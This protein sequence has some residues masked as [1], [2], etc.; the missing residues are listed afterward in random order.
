MTSPGQRGRASSL[1]SSLPRSR[2][3][4]W[5]V[6]S[7]PTS[8]GQPPIR[9]RVS[10]RMS[11]TRSS[12]AN[13]EQHSQKR[14]SSLTGFFNR[15][16]PSSRPEQGGTRRTSNGTGDDDADLAM[17]PNEL[18]GWNLAQEKNPAYLTPMPPEEFNH[19]RVWSWS[20]QKGDS[21]F[22]ENLPRDRSRGREQR[23]DTADREPLPPRKSEALTR[24]E[25][26]ELLKS[27]EETRRSRRSLKESGDWLGVQGADPYSGKFAVLTPTDTPSSETTNTSTRSRLA[28]LARKK[29]T[30]KLEY[31]QI[32]VLEEQEKDK[33]KLDKEQAKLN[34]IERVKEDLRR[35]NQFAKWRQHKRQWSSAA[36]PNLS[37]IAQ[38]VDSVAL[39]SSENSS[40]LSSGMPTDSLSSDVED[41]A[42]VV[43]NFS[44]P[45]RPP[46]S[47]KAALQAHAGRLSSDSTGH[48]GHTR[49]NLSSD[50]VI[51]NSSGAN[52]EHV[53]LTRPATQ[54]SG[55]HHSV[56]Q[57]DVERVKSE[58]HF[59]WRRRRVTDPGKSAISRA[60]S[61]LMSRTAQNL[62]FNTTEHVQKDH[63]ADLAIPDYHLHLL[64]PEGADTADS[65]STLS[66]G[67]PS[68]TPNQTSLG[69]SGNRTALSSSTN[70][71]NLQE[72]GRTSQ[73]RSRLTA[74]SSQSKLKGIMRR[75]SIYRRL[76]QNRL[77]S[78]QAK[79]TETHQT[80]PPTFS[81]VQDHA[82]EN[83]P[84]PTQ[85]FQSQHLPSDQI[86]RISI[87]R[88]GNKLPH[89][90]NHIKPTRRESVSTPITTITGCVPDQQNQPEPRQ[91]KWNVELNQM[92]GAATLTFPD[93]DIHYVEPVQMP[94]KCMTP[95][96]P[97]TPRSGSS[98]RGL[99]QATPVIGTISV[100]HVTLEK[101]PP[102]RISTPTTP[103]LCRII[104]HNAEMKEIE[105]QNDTNGMEKTETIRTETSRRTESKGTNTQNAPVQ[106]SDQGRHGASPARN[107]VTAVQEAR[108]R[109]SSEEQRESMVEEAAR[110]AV[111]RS[112]AKE[113][114]RSKSADR[115]KSRTPSPTRRRA[116]SNH[117]SSSYNKTAELKHLPQ[118]QQQK[119]PRKKRPSEDAEGT[120]LP[121]RPERVSRQH[122]SSSSRCATADSVERPDAVVVAAAA[123][124]CKT[125]YIV[126]LG[127]ACTWWIMVQ[128]AFDQQSELWRRKHKKE[129]TWKDVGVFTSAGMFCLA[130]ALGGWYSLKALWWAVEQ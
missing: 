130:G 82:T 111:L 25:V 41:N 81:E 57:G 3:S 16:L 51:H 55:K 128:P 100:H 21:R 17:N 12:A 1:F 79:N 54:P 39:G 71:V 64:S 6:S 14:T 123:R 20:P 50:T 19:R 60:R 90:G 8:Q 127:L 37:P 95:S 67:S 52:L 126:F 125:I 11:P 34:K 112:R 88:A 96:P 89:I 4:D 77:A 46:V 28:S 92:D 87:E 85:E 61:R 120:G 101:K 47:S 58:R 122:S 42:S 69:I 26:H 48:Q 124:F 30:A 68:M 93:R 103:R 106:K 114:V 45:T 53:P 86:G 99:A 43:P 33:A 78:T 35:Q 23:P 119:R 56:G 5:L 97:A 98:N 70:L 110:V 31:E 73:D 129:S 118:Q 75:P 59:L 121:S 116:M 40:L 63:F 22:V 105:I 27:K 13:G 65:Q 91:P 29:K 32:T 18:T 109:L 36:E 49:F 94:E 7:S 72:N 2:S 10:T 9:Q 113:M 80:S 15:I 115:K 44:R 117:R 107:P 62:T 102:T 74:T 84:E 66:D 83:I 108:R 76:V 24:A 104:Q 38:S